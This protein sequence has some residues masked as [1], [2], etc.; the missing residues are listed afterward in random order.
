M[1]KKKRSILEREGV[2]DGSEGRRAGKE[3]ERGECC[4]YVCECI[5]QNRAMANTLMRKE[6]RSI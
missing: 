2:G 3:R 5:A 6:K 1:R 4:T